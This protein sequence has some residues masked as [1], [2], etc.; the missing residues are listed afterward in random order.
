[1]KNP[2]KIILLLV[3]MFVSTASCMQAQEGSRGV[4]VKGYDFVLQDL[5]GDSFVLSSYR[6]RQ[7]VILFFWTTWCPHCRNELS[8]LSERYADLSWEGWEVFTIAVSEP[9]QKVSDFVKARGVGLRVLL[10]RDMAVTRDFG[11]IGVPTFVL[12]DKEGVVV[13]KGHAF[14]SR[15]Y[16]DLI[17]E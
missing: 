12:L 17:K 2:A 3:F 6:G 10:D 15:D 8:D 16:K 11:V 1:M 13:F 9:A 5:S 14:P 7:P 4:E